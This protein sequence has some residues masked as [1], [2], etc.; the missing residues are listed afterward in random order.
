MKTAISVPDKIFE[1]A[2]RMA[3]QLGTSRSELYEK[4]LS[5][6]LEKHKSQGVTER[7]NQIYSEGAQ[8]SELDSAL[9]TLQIKSLPREDW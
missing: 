3:T 5:E 2:D 6:Y 8:D 1:A 9:N 7:L 4:A